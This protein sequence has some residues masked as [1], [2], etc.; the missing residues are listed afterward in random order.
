MPPPMS[1]TVLA[2]CVTLGHH[3]SYDH[4]SPY[5]GPGGLAGRGGGAERRVSGP[6]RPGTAREGARGR[7]AGLPAAGGERART[8]GSVDAQGLLPSMKGI[9]DTG[10]LV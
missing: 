4:N 6:D 5:E 9:A 8:E 2:C 1:W 7:R 10:F 3:E